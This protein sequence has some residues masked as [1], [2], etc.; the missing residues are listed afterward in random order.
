[1]MIE[2]SIQKSH[3][4][5]AMLMHPY[6]VVLKIDDFKQVLATRHLVATQDLRTRSGIVWVLFVPVPVYWNV[7]TTTEFNYKY[8]FDIPDSQASVKL[9]FELWI[10]GG[11]GSDIPLL[12][13]NINYA[14]GTGTDPNLRTF[15]FSNPGYGAWLTSEVKTFGMK[16]VNTIAIHENPT[17]H[18]PAKDSFEYTMPFD[19]NYRAAYSFDHLQPSAYDY[20]SCY[21]FTDDP[22]G[23]N[24]SG[25]TVTETEDSFIKVLGSFQDHYKVVELTSTSGIGSDAWTPRMLLSESSG[26]LQGQYEFWFAMGQTNGSFEVW[27]YSSSGMALGFFWF[28]IRSDGTWAFKYKKTTGTNWDANEINLG[29]YKAHRWYHVRVQWDVDAGATSNGALKMWVDGSIKC[30]VTNMIFDP[31]DGFG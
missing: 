8:Y 1:M 14:L 16:R 24:P 9:T 10:D 23:D 27:A 28:D 18:Y 19:G 6:F 13:A 7:Y 2:V 17:G 22:V 4:E 26:C 5:N 3:F 30:D 25:W 15:N 11:T 21:S 20:T 29:I 31:S 12:G